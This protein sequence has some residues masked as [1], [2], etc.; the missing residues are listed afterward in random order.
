MCPNVP[1]WMRC[2]RLTSCDLSTGC[3]FDPD[4]VGWSYQAR[5]VALIEIGAMVRRFLRTPAIDDASLNWDG[6]MQVA[7]GG[8]FLDSDHTVARCRDQF[9]PSVFQ[10]D[11]RD[12]YEKNDRR[13]AFEAARDAALASIAAAP[14]AGCWTRTRPARLPNWP[15]GPMNISWGSIRGGSRPSSPSVGESPPG[16]D[17]L[18]L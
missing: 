18:W 13:G 16:R 11:G 5:L 3:P 10:R 12:D 8:H 4:R 9:I 14:G 17:Q 15:P 2:S 1:F 7:V 6:M